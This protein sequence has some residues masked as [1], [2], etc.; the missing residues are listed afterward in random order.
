[1]R[2]KLRTIKNGLRGA[3]NK[4]PSNISELDDALEKGM[5]RG[6][7]PEE[8][9]P[10]GRRKPFGYDKGTH[11]F[12]MRNMPDNPGNQGNRGY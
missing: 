11:G 5:V 8:H 10:K 4:N 2:L 6:L 9:G 7:E 1:M 12:A 3:P